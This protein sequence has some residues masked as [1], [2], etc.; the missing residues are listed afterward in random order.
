[1]IFHDKDDGRAEVILRSS[2]GPFFVIWRNTA[3]TWADGSKGTP[4]SPQDLYDNFWVL[5]GREAALLTQE[6][7]TAVPSPNPIPSPLKGS[8]PTV[9][10]KL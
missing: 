1:M 5:S 4:F 2:G 6:A 7:L 10:R 3:G 9:R 8:V